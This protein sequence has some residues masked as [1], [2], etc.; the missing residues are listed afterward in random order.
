M[1]PGPSLTTVLA[2]ERL[3][4]TPGLTYCCGNTCC[5]PDTAGA[6]P[7]ANA[8]DSRNDATDTYRLYI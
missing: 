5:P 1:G 8:T 4:K 6:A 2:Q 3:L 7:P